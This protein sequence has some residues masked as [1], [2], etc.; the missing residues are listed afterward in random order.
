MAKDCVLCRKSLG[1]FSQ[2]VK[3][4]N[5]F[6]CLEC[7]KGLGF[8]TSMRD[9]EK[10]MQYSE[11]D[12]KNIASGA[13]KNPAEIQT[14]F[15]NS[16]IRAIKASGTNTLM[17]KGS[18]KDAAAMLRNDETVIAAISANVAL[19]EPQGAIKVK[20]ASFKDKMAGVVVLTDQRVVFAASSGFKATRTIYLTDIDAVDDSSVGAIIGTVLR[21]QS[22]S[23]VLAIDGTAAFLVPFRNKVQEAMHAARVS[24]AKPASV[25]VQQES[26]DADE[27]MKFKQLLDAGVISEEEFNAKK[28]Q[29]LGL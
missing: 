20:T 14:A 2:K 23:T 29:L 7:W 1:A 10:A 22:V 27:I 4:Q 18:I 5:G 6:V 16:I 21:I 13:V 11:S 19:G 3:I 17:Q 26:S 15:E 24:A 25:V 9:L 28:K 8:G 12:I